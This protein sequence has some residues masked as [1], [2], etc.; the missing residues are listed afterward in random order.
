MRIAASILN[1]S[2]AWRPAAALGLLL[3]LAACGGGGSSSGDTAETTQAQSLSATATT[4]PQETAQGADAVV[5]TALA[6]DISQLSSPAGTTA[7]VAAAGSAQLQGTQSCVGGGSVSVVMTGPSMAALL[8]GEPDAGEVTQL[9]YSACRGPDTQVALDGTVTMMVTQADAGGFGVTLSTGS[10]TLQASFP[11]STLT[12][13]GSLSLQ[14]TGTVAS[15][16]SSSTSSSWSADGLT[17]QAQRNG[18]QA[19]LSF[20]GSGA[21]TVQWLNAVPQSS[22]YQGS[23]SLGLQ[24]SRWTGSLTVA[25][26]GAMAFDPQGVPQSGSLAL[27]LGLYHWVATL[28][29]GSVTVTVD[30][31]GDGTVDRTSTWT[32]SDWLASAAQ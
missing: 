12:W 22:T 32:V 28:A 7:K 8:N 25:T 6:V 16:G 13:S 30:R 17:L 21:R 26:D 29:G 23:S 14:R 27:S 31:N 5:D 24:S 10:G 3:T 9:T 2:R 1:P 20:S 4:T 15:S 19:D 11:L 18:H